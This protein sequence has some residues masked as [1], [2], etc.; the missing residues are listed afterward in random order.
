MPAAPAA[1]P[2][3]VP[4]PATGTAR[5]RLRVCFF[6]TWAGPLE[7]VSTYAGRPAEAALRAGVADPGDPSLLSRARL[8][9]D[10]YTE[11]ARCFAGLQHDALDWLP[12]WTCGRDGILE[13]ARAPREPEEERWLVCMAHQPESFGPLAG[14]IFGYL[15][16]NGVRI[17]FYSFDEASRF[18]PCFAAIAPHLSVL[19]HDEYPLVPAG[20]AALRPGCLRLHRS[21]V[22]NLIP[23]AAEF[24]ERPEPKIHFLG[25]Q[26][27]LTPHRR[28]QLA[29]LEQRFPG[30]V[31][32]SCDHSTPVAARG[33]L[34]IYQVGFCPEGRKFS[35]PAM[36]RTHTD[37][38]F[39]CGCAGMVPV[40]ED[41]AAGGRL[42]DLH[43]SGLIVRYDHGDLASLAAACERAL[44]FSTTERRRIY[45]HFNRHE[46]VGQVVAEALLEAGR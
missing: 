9:R 45:E 36:S 28:H 37:R 30:R 21:W 14:R 35:T 40:C 20:A 7:P 16:Q 33:G 44:A 13:L 19:I 41:S 22:A 31:V 42:E 10:W 3:S 46:T 8:D 38:P 29:F 1:P 34:G 24:V 18:M 12:A 25:S 43:R 4:V 6:N 32:A 15:A 26:L 2:R 27:G 39:W 23:F 11:N 17:L 5:R